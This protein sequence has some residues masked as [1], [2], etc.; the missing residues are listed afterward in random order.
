MKPKEI[1]KTVKKML[2][3]D[4]QRHLLNSSEQYQSNQIV[5]HVC[6]GKATEARQILDYIEKLERE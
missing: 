2:E 3:Q 5:R 6:A 4:E 1:L